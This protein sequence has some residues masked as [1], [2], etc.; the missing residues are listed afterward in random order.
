MAESAVTELSPPTPAEMH[1]WGLGQGQTARSDREKELPE[2][3]WHALDRVRSGFKPWP[4]T[5]QISLEEQIQYLRTHLPV[6]E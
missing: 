3:M 1:L 6:R 4:M 2:H 5:G